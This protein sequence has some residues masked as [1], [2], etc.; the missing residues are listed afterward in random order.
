M[1]QH[2]P[3]QHI[4]IAALLF[5]FLISM[6]PGLKGAWVDLRF[7]QGWSLYI[8]RNGLCNTYTS[9]TDYPPVYQYI[10]WIF[11]LLAGTEEAILKYTGYLRVF[12]IAADYWALWI[13]YKWIDRRVDYIFILLISILNIAYSYDTLIWGQVD[14]ILAAFLIA[15]LYYLYRE[16]RLLSAVILV[17]AFNTKPQTIVLIP[18]WGLLLISSLHRARQWRQLVWILAT[19]II[20]QALILLPFM[21]GEAGLAAIWRPITNA[22]NNYPTVSLH[23]YN[24]WYFFSSQIAFNAV[25]TTL[26]PIGISYFHIGL[27][28]F[29]IA[30]FIVL[31]PVIRHTLQ[32]LQNR[33]HPPLSRDVIWLSAALSV[34]VF[35]YF[36][37]RMHE[38]Y[39]YY[40]FIFLTAHMF[41]TG[42]H[43]LYVLLSFT[44]FLNLESLVNWFQLS[45]YDTAIFDPRLI[46][47]LNALLVIFSTLQ[48]YR[49][50]KSPLPASRH[51]AP[52]I[53]PI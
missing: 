38:R 4:L 32:T 14:A 43:S 20:T 36:N 44:F 47:T 42:R 30:L 1:Q 48:L 2:I 50:A 46:A 19:I 40:A 9:G 25:D 41:Y 53:N 18:L 35:F 52:S 6:I 10:L 22:I 3:K 5:L 31:W 33:D 15:S 24:I 8:H 12:T 49:S 34:L 16:K 21:F 26:S 29:S 37:T 23:A 13:V 27:I 39:H 51:P 45:N 11:T 7:W 17:L 28:T